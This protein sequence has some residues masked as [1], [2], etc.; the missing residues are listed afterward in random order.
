LGQK[1]SKGIGRTEWQEKKRVSD[2]VINRSS[3]PVDGQLAAC[4][5]H[6]PQ[7]RANQLNVGQRWCFHFVNDAYNRESASTVIR[8]E[9]RPII[10]F[11]WLLKHGKRTDGS[12]GT[13][14][15]ADPAIAG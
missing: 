5:Y 8:F 2:D 14:S 7:T 13:N 1:N 15:R 10:S 3:R 9:W 4:A 11:A 12:G 6:Q